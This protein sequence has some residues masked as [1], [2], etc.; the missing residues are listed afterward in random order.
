MIDERNT[1]SAFLRRRF[2]KA[3]A[4]IGVDAGFDCPNRDGTI[5]RDGCIFCDN[6][7]FRAGSGRG[8]IR[9]QLE[10][11]LA[12]LER[13][14]RP[15]LALAYFQSFTN[16]HASPA[17][18][19]DIYGEALAVD[20][21]V[22][23]A[24]STRPDA[25]G[26]EVVAVLAEVA[27]RTF[28]WVE[29]GLQSASDVAL[30]RARRGHTVADFV[31]AAGRLHDAGIPVVAHLMLGLPG[32]TEADRETCA[33]M[34]GDLGVWGVKFH[35]LQVV[36]G[37]ELEREVIAGRVQ[38]PTVEEYAAMLD[39]MLRLLPKDIVIHRLSATCHPEHLSPSDPNGPDIRDRVLRMLS[40]QE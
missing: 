39:T 15:R 10:E 34:L 38:V 5:S 18:L 11:G 8:S 9:S 33:R 22:G 35:Q 29:L 28:L 30:A 25:V 24:V 27:A 26:P 40:G 31:V 21:V 17:R 2:G 37:T 3:V 1:L 20:G 14:K 6:N 13:Q 23:L 19:R 4:K 16:T 32:E 36:C 7:A 12:R